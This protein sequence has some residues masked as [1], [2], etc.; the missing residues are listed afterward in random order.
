[1][2]P[3][4]PSCAS[5]ALA[6]SSSPAVAV[7]V[8]VEDRLHQVTRRYARALCNVIAS[9]GE[10]SSGQVRAIKA[11]LR[12]KGFAPDIVESVDALLEAA[13]GVEDDDLVYETQVLIQGSSLVTLKKP[14]IQDMYRVAAAN[15]FPESQVYATSLV[16]SQVGITLDEI[17]SMEF[18]VEKC[19]PRSPNLE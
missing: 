8:D 4:Y 9:G 3:M 15:D 13:T 5:V 16:A 10:W 6:Y 7:E 1:V 17:H 19:S 14:L 18:V 11:C 2:R 12:S